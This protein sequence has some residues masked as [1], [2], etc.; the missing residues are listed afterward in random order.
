MDSKRMVFF[1]F[2]NQ[3]LKTDIENL[4]SLVTRDVSTLTNDIILQ[5]NSDRTK[6]RASFST[7]FPNLRYILLE[8][9]EKE[10]R[11]KSKVKPIVEN[12][13]TLV[14]TSP[15]IKNFPRFELRVLTPNSTARNSLHP[16]LLKGLRRT[17]RTTRLF[18][19]PFS[20]N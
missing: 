2:Q 14:E 16:F 5:S 12:P 13:N 18:I 3:Q 9:L 15:V 17:C 19:R 11:A 20:A 4:G 10:V 7:M 8:T 6:A 1:G